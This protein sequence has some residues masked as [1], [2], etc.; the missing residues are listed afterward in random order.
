MVP[1]LEP[2]VSICIPTYNNATMLQEAVGSALAQTYRSTEVIVTDNASTD[3]TASVVGAIRDPRLRYYRH[4]TNLGMVGNFRR[5]LSM[6]R[7]RHV[8][9][10]SSDDL[11]QPEFAEWAV[12]ALE[13]GSGAA[14]A[15]A[16]NRF[17]GARRGVSVWPFPPRIGGREFILESLERAQNLVHLCG[18]MARR[19]CLERVGLEEMTFFDWTLWLRLASRGDVLY[20]PRLMA[21]YRSHPGNETGR[22][23]RRQSTHL[24]ALSRAVLAYLERE[25]PEE[26]LRRAACR[27]VDQLFARYTGQLGRASQLSSVAFVADLLACWKVSAGFPMKL[28]ASL[29]SIL[30]RGRNRWR[31]AIQ[32]AV[33]LRQRHAPRSAA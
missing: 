6:S 28:R 13:D 14:F 31:P 9:F 20:T 24:L 23:M 10:L 25:Q 26:E 8:C 32:C 22:T 4:S 2:L 33:K 1:H 30:I 5:A 27:C 15:F 16:G 11:L 18:A 17:T 21:S 7:G 3:H 19:E 29:R 12:G